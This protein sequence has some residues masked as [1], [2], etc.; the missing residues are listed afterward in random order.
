[1]CFSIIYLVNP[2]ICFPGDD[3]Y[4][5]RS[6][7]L[8]L[9]YFALNNSEINMHTECSVVTREVDSVTL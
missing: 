4:N 5:Y 1:M 8:N 9:S 7:D 3:L 6:T 2:G